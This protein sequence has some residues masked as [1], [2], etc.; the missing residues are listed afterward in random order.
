M[1]YVEQI[2]SRQIVGMVV[3]VALL[4]GCSVMEQYHFPPAQNEV[5]VKVKLAFSEK[6]PN[7]VGQWDKVY[8][9]KMFDGTMRYQIQTADAKGA[10]HTVTLTADGAEIVD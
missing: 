7:D 4:G 2:M 9:Q 10:K 5:P 3:V 6:Y 8:A 1:L